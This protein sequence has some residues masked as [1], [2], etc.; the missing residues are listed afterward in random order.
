MEEETSNKINLSRTNQDI[1]N[2]GST[3]A[4][5]ILSSDIEK[6]IPKPPAG[7]ASKKE[8][9]LCLDVLRGLTMVGMIM[10]DSMGDFDH[11]IW[12]LNETEWDGLTTADCIFPSF[13]FIMGLAV[14]LALKREDRTK[15]ITW[16]RIIKRFILLFVIGMALNF[17]GRIPRIF[18]TSPFIGFRIMGVLQ[19]ISLCYL[20][21]SVM[22]L[23]L[24]NL[25]YHSVVLAT[26]IGLYLGFMYGYPVPAFDDKTPCGKGV[27][28]P[29]C[30]FNGY[31]NRLIFGNSRKF[32]M[33]P[34]DPEGL[35]S[36]LTSLMNTFSGLCFSLLM[37]YNT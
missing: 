1:N 14:P 2:E 20:T 21:V 18:T 13:L 27:V 31:F 19:R 23:F 26:C 4:N 10:V 28:S 3:I 29:E 33:Y 22:Y 35:F 12:P 37:R 6:L 25:A 9:L 7:S 5:N 32:M 34:N 30:N 8:R 24:P 15:G 17:Q 36:T 16:Y 11:V